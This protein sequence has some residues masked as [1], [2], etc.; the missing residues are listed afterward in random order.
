[1]AVLRLMHRLVFGR[2]LYR[3]IG[4][5]L[6]LKDAIDIAGRLPKLVDEIRPIRHQAAGSDEEAFPIDRRQLV[7]GRQRDDQI[8]MNAP[9]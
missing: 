1:M 3:K 6:A 9:P 2:R 7:P 8:A 4:R 5:L